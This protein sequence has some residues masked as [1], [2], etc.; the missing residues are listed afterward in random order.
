MNPK[1]KSSVVNV[2]ETLR[3]ARIISGHVLSARDSVISPMTAHMQAPQRR[4]QRF[5]PLLLSFKVLAAAGSGRSVI[6]IVPSTAN[7][8]L[9]FGMHSVR[10]FRNA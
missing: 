6:R 3:R 5:L 7:V 1:T 10:E 4:K 9:T 2:Q 8:C